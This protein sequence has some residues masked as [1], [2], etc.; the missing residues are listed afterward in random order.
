MIALLTGG[1]GA[2]PNF[3]SELYEKLEFEDLTH[4]GFA[5][6]WYPQGI[7]GRIVIDPEISF[8]RPTLVNW[9]V[10]TDN[11]YD[12]YLGEKKKIEPVSHWFNIPAQEIQAAVEFEANL[13]A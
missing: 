3:I 11:I 10:S 9:G 2:M 7:D 5:K 6:K 13:W 1:Q 8:G 4:F 12:L